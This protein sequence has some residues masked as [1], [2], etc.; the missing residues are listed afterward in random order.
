MLDVY[1]AIACRAW[2]IA[3]MRGNIGGGQSSFICVVLRG[4]DS[5]NGSSR[6]PT[7]QSAWPAAV[8][9][10][11]YPSFISACTLCSDTLLSTIAGRPMAPLCWIKG[12]GE[13]LRQWEIPHLQALGVK[14]PPNPNG[15]LM[16]ESYMKV[17][18]GRVLPDLQGTERTGSIMPYTAF[19]QRRRHGRIGTGRCECASAGGSRRGNAQ[20][21]TGHALTWCKA[22][23]VCRT[24]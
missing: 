12:H 21:A 13:I 19:P 20:G 1:W 11:P 16:I 3:Q 14:T 18:Q 5:H 6:W 10:I 4:W 24:A 17:R 2:S 23:A 9:S 8:S 7:C 22:H 15:Y